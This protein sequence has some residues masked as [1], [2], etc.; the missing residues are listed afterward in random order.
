MRAFRKTSESTVEPVRVPELRDH[1]RIQSTAEDQLLALYL[2]AAR[3]EA[4]NRTHRALLP[5]QWCLVLDE[6]EDSVELPRP[7]LSTA[8]TDVVINYTNTT[9]GASTVQSTCYVVDADSEPGRIYESYDSEFP[10]D[11]R[12]CE[13][14]VRITYRSGYSTA[15]EACP[16]PI[17]IWILMRAGA[18]YENREP[19]GEAKLNELPRTFVDGLLD[20]YIVHN[21]PEGDTD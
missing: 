4:E 18:M 14:A 12:D 7:P 13:G 16:T 20:A 11:I 10:D 3:V 21:F 19:L 6:L 15:T 2:Q 9:G 1:L 17:R 8:S 5:S